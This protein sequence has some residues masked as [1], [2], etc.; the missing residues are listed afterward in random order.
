MSEWGG[1]QYEAYGK[2]SW[3]GT[4]RVPTVWGKVGCGGGVRDQGGHLIDV[5]STGAASAA[6]LPS[7]DHEPN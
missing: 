6:R 5:S 1:R 4:T 2:A 3:G 7:Q